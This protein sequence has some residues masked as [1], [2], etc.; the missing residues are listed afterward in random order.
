MLAAFPLTTARDMRWWS[1]YRSLGSPDMSTSFF[2]RKLKKVLKIL[3][4][5]KEDTWQQWSKPWRSCQYLSSNDLLSTSV[6]REYQY[7]RHQDRNQLIFSGEGQMMLLVAA[8]NKYTRLWKFW[9]EIARV[10]PLWLRACTPL[11]YLVS[12]V[13]FFQEKTKNKKRAIPWN[14]RTPQTTA[15]DYQSANFMLLRIRIEKCVACCGQVQRCATLI[16][17]GLSMEW[18]SYGNL[19]IPWDSY[20]NPMG[21]VPWDGTGINCYGMGMG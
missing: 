16:C 10:P 13:N 12:I 9:R 5:K 7:V 21:N 20:G 1:H 11:T 8:P 17:T 4:N 6:Q 3:G 2:A 15:I 14:K 18:D 19:G